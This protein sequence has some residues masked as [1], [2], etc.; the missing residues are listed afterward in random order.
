MIVSNAFHLLHAELEGPFS[1]D[2]ACRVAGTVKAANDASVGLNPWA[3]ASGFKFVSATVAAADIIVV[4][5]AQQQSELSA[6]L[7]QEFRSAFRR[8]EVVGLKCTRRGD[9]DEAE[10]GT[11]TG[12]RRRSI[13]ATDD[14]EQRV[15]GT[16][17]ALQQIRH[18]ITTDFIVMSCDLIGH[19]DFFALAS[20]INE[21]AQGCA[22][23]PGGDRWSQLNGGIAVVYWRSRIVAPSDTAR[24]AKR[25]CDSLVGVLPRVFA[26]VV[27]SMVLSH[28][29]LLR[30]ASRRRCRVHSLFNVARPVG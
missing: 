28:L 26:G 5:Q 9:D 25:Q 10:E 14:P 11:S 8:L 4:T 3:L 15:C 30:S 19:V 16:A 22:G 6:Y 27:N 1:W 29:F 20:E 12:N 2:A 23:K 24:P 18:L 17:E 13:D 7:Q 21:K